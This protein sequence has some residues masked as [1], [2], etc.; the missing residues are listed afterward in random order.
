MVK[1]NKITVVGAGN[2]GA[3]CAHWAAAKELGNIV[4]VD[5]V[6]GAPQGKSLDLSEATPVIGQDV[7][8][9]GTNGYDE[10]ADSD[11]VIITAG[12]PRRPG[13]TRDD[14]LATNAGIVSSVVGEIAPRS[15]DATLILVS[16][17]LDVMTFVALKKSGFAPNKVV[18]MAGILDTARYRTFI[19]MELGVSVED[20]T[21]LVLGGHGDSMVPLPRY[22]S[23]G[24]SPLSLWMDD[25]KIE[26]IVQ[27]TRDGGIEI[28]NFLKTGGA[29]YAPSAGAVQMAEAILKDKKRV[30]PCSAYMTGQYGLDDVYIG[31]PIVLGANGVEKVIELDLNDAEREALHA[32]AAGV[33]KGIAK[34]SL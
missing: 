9:T 4:L 3:T 2:V 1:R 27:R 26:N 31:V 12:L 6:E 10:T 21:A 22:T 30:L 15:P 33:K 28:V 32:S 25:E 11:V 24:G 20:V 17:P 7:T 23:I 18:G 5:I 14:L 34:L 16:N 19:A 8:V 29:F 13:M